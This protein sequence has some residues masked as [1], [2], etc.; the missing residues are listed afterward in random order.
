M[1]A[2]EYGIDGYGRK[3]AAKD[4][5]SG[6]TYTCYYCKEKIHV[7]KGDK[8]SPY[9]AH[10]PIHNRTP[11]QMAC[12][13]YKGHG[14]SAGYIKNEGDKIY[15][16]NGG[17]P[18]HLVEYTK[19]KYELIAMFPPLSNESMKK[20]SEWD[21]KIRIT[22]DGRDQVFSAWNLRRYKIKTTNSWIYTKS[23]DFKYEIDEVKR[24]WLWGIKGIAFDEDLF[25][26]DS[27][28]AIRVAS[29]GTVSVGKEYLFIHRCG[30][31]NNRPGLTFRKK[32]VFTL[33][34]SF[35]SRE[36]DVY[37]VV[38]TKV[39]EDSISFIQRKG[40]NL[41]E[42]SDDLIPMWPPAVIEGKELI[43]NTGDDTAY[44]YHKKVSNQQVF[45]WRGYLPGKIIEKEDV[46]KCFTNNNSLLLSDYEFNSLAKEIR[47]VLTQERNNYYR[48]R[49]F[50]ISLC[51]KNEEGV[52]SDL[53]ELMYKTLDEKVYVESSYSGISILNTEGFFVLG[54]RKKQI[55]EMLN[56]G[57]LWIEYQPFGRKRIL[58]E[59]P[60]IV[61]NEMKLDAIPKITD[62]FVRKL[63]NCKST[64]IPESGFLD[65]WIIYAKDNKQID[66][67]KIFFAWKKIGVIPD[68]L[69]IIL[70][71][72]EN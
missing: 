30:V 32:G 49:I 14:A 38:V 36:Y 51:F 16:F 72:L 22:G 50:D 13:G 64:Y 44:L 67:L 12:E 6:R 59:S 9:F 39:T 68:K 34:D 18:V 24:K 70:R 40:Y 37:S 55:A 54:S 52:I 56:K 65:K 23:Q 11:Q 43:Y 7:R 1:L 57:D 35:Y 71:E 26:S 5:Y 60:Q 42:K 19:G 46:F 2:I 62:D 21:A 29:M 8:K 28:G 27:T 48:E 31:L 10:M 58:R 25:R 47:Y 4:A 63:Y 17:V 20:I 33:A 66:L 41:I 15:I 45:Q 69:P 61:E 3:V 53:E